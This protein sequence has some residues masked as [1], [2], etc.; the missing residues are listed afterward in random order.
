MEK[1]LSRLFDYQKF[2]E[3]SDL[4]DVIKDVE[5]RYPAGGREL[6]ENELFFVNAAGDISAGDDEDDSRPF[7]PIDPVMRPR[8]DW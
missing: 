4:A 8:R 7:K 2:A 3:N 6:S 1:K 5:S